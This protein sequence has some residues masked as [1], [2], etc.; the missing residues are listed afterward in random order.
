MYEEIENLK[1]ILSNT[2]LKQIQ[3]QNE[4]FG[5]LND[6]QASPRTM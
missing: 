5:G 2:R 4:N 3:Q 1:L 6:E